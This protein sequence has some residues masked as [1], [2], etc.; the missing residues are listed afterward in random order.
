MGIILG[1]ALLAG[2]DEGAG[3]HADGGSIDARPMPDLISP[4]EANIAAALGCGGPDAGAPARPDELQRHDLDVDA[5]PDALCSD[6]SPAFLYFRPYR[7]DE[8]RD[9]WIIHLGGG[10]ACKTPEE[11]AAAWCRCDGA[12]SCPFAAT[13]G[14]SVDGMSGRGGDASRPGAGVLRRDLAPPSPFADYNQAF[15]HYCTADRWVGS[16]RGVTFRTRHPRT[17]DPVEYV[18]HFLGARVLDGA[19]ATLRQ[20]R[21][22]PLVYEL[23]GGAVPM[24]DLDDAD[25]VIFTGESA[26]AVGLVHSI[27]VLADTLRGYSSKCA[28]TV[29]PP[30]VRVVFDSGVGPERSRLDWRM[31][32]GGERTYDEHIA[33]LAASPSLRGARRDVSCV[34]WHR[35]NRPGTE[36]LCLDDAHVIRNHVSAHM[37]V[38]MGLL[39]EV[40]AGDYGRL[41]LADPVLGPLAAP[42]FAK[43]LGRELAGFPTLR[44]TA[45]EGPYVFR[46]PGVFA[47]RCAGHDTLLRDA[48]VDGTRVTTGGGTFRLFD[49]LA[50]WMDGRSPTAVLAVD[51][52]GGDTVC[53][54]P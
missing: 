23:G 5:Y 16:A 17:G 13:T 31:N 52:N 34:G 11:C 45:E 18:M 42:V 40:I 4:P 33:A 1:L 20:D 39:D 10:G 22:D 26:G 53:A 48:E 6:G 7:G 46:P 15:L 44:Q 21:A 51:P 32:P 50:A 27:D 24:P 19:L 9:R 14:L 12:S 47:P 37:F 35:L 25:L 29:C 54:A 8:N 30:E 3:G 38:R 43:V 36:D 49:L 28:D 2:C 41:G